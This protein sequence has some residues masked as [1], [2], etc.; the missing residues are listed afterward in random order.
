CPRP[1][2][3][4]NGLHSG[5][6][7]NKFSRGVTVY[8][9]CRD[10]Y[11][12]VGNASLNCTESGVWSRPLPRCEAIGC[13]MPEVQNGNIYEPQSTYKAGETLHF[14]C[15]AGYAAEDTYESRCQPGGTWDPPELICQRVRPCPMPPGVRNGY[16]NGQGKAVFT[17]GMS[18]TYTCN[19]GYYLVGN[20]VVSCRVSGNWSRP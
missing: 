12:L 1:P 16:H 7:S 4:A 20:A 14:D 5:Q 19:P 6:S 3:I 13:E 18:V 8:Y 2:N 15:N 17:M 10:G 11:E 9:S